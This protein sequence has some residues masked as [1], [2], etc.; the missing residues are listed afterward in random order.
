MKWVAEIVHPSGKKIVA[1][2]PEF[3]WRD[4]G[5]YSE[6]QYETEMYSN[7]ARHLFVQQLLND[8]W[9]VMTT[10]DR[11]EVQPLKR[12]IGSA[13]SDS[14]ASPADLLKQLASLRDAGILTEEK[15]QVK[16]AEILRRM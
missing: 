2:S 13:P 9:E 4:S 3:M 8:G 5:D 1:Q 14:S 12:Q 10:N 11:G 6:K 7:D 15:F 16:K